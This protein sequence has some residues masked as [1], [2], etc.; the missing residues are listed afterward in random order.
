VDAERWGRVQR[1]FHEALAAE[2]RRTLLDA[3]C[4]DDPALRAEVEAML[5]A[6][7]DG[8]PILDRG[9]AD[10]ARDLLGH[11]ANNAGR[12]IGRYRLIRAIGEGGMG[13]VYLAERAS[14]VGGVVAIKILRDAW[15]SPARRERFANE[16]RTLAQLTHP[17]IAHLYDA[18]AL[19]DGTPWFAMEYVDGVPLTEYSVTH[20]CGIPER[21]RLFRAIGDAVHFAHRHL[22]IHRD[23]KPSNILV[24]PD[25]TVA[26]LDFGIAKQLESLEAPVDHTRTGLRFLTPAY[27]APEQLRGDGAGV[28]TDVYSLGVVLYE[29]ITGRLPFD[30]ASRTPGEAEAMILRHDP[31][32]P[33]AVAKRVAERT[34][35]PPGKSSW[36]DLDVLC[37]T[38]MH[39]DPDRRY[40]SVEALMRDVDHYLKDQPL[41]AHADS[42]HY[43][44][45]K[46]ATRHRRPL[47][48]LAAVV[49]VVIAL[50]VFYTVGLA[51]ARNAALAEAARTQRIQ[52][53]MLNLFEGGDE[54]TGPAES[55]RVVT[56]VDRGVR[57][58]RA[59]DREPAVQA[60]LYTTLGSIYQQLGQ[61][62]LADSLIRA[63]LDQRKAIFGADHAEVATSLIT[64]GLLRSDQAKLD[65]AERLVRDGYAMDVRHL[66]P[67]DPTLARAAAALGRVLRESGAYDSAIRVLT[68]AVRL[69]SAPGG[70]SND[71]SE[72]LTTLANADYYAG[73]YAISDSINRQVL[74]MDRVLHGDRHPSGGRAPVPRS[75]GHRPRVVWDGQSRD[76]IDPADA[77]ANARVRETL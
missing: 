14:E 48:A 68:K 46:F 59:L 1:L 35:V 52:H 71:L 44:A 65:E 39:K 67:N 12:R 69:Q 5:D 24:R 17:S 22:V 77:F 76:R 50:T 54:T 4:A 15:L 36:A 73:H 20:A 57:Q 13:I 11:D 7:E 8:V 16:Q 10:V 62:D 42:V 75:P 28:Q 63:G 64:L 37:L 45:A 72:T 2:D 26:L 58:A 6:D 9:V 21:L 74:A 53:F 32:K 30:L 60:E 18:D 38:A 25:G 49:T 3:E 61:L 70:D 29:L 33:S 43:R 40:Q 51:R 66:P 27:A 23:L 34:G 19:S 47:A 56:L 55:L 41:E 31:V